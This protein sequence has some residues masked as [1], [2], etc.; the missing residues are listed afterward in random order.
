MSEIVGAW[1]LATGTLLTMIS[2]LWLLVAA[3]R[4]HIAWGLAGTFTFPVGVVAFG[5]VKFRRARRP[6][7]LLCFGVLLGGIPFFAN[8]VERYVWGL[9]ERERVID[10]RLHLVLTGWDRKDYSILTRKPAVVVLEMANPDVTDETLELLI[11]LPELRELTINDSQTTDAG[12]S[13]LQKLPNLETLRIARTKITKEGVAAFVAKPPTKLKN[14]DVSGN[15]IPASVL[16][17]WKNADP[18]HRRY[19]Q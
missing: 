16:R 2:L 3:Y 10:G 13:I 19:L 9:G 5:L 18:E 6:L 1:L 8:V 11:D 4:T 12:L 14:L 7:S 17:P 15:Q